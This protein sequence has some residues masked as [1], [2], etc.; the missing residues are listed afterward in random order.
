MRSNGDLAR[1][2][3]RLRPLSDAPWSP[4]VKVNDDPGTASQFEPAIGVDSS[5]NAYAV[6]ADW[7]NSD[8]DIYFSYRPAGGSWGAS[9]RVDDDAGTA[10]QYSPDIAVDSSR[11]AYAVWEDWRNGDSD[12]YFSYRPVGG[13]WGANVKVNDDPG[14]TPQE[15]PAIAVDSSGNAY[16]VW[17]DSRN[18]IFDIYFSYR[19]AGGSWGVNVKVNDDPGTADPYQPAIGVDS[20]GNAYAVWE[21]WR[22]GTDDIYFSYRPAGGSW[23]VNVRVDDDP[24]TASQF[25]PAIAVGPSGN[26]YA[27]WTDWRTPPYPAIYFSYRPAGGGWGANVEVNDD[28]GTGPQRYPAIA[29]DPSGNAYAVWTEGRPPL[30]DPDIYFS[31]RPAG[32]SWGASVR[33]DDD[34]GTAYQWYP[35]IAVDP[36]GNA[37][38]VWEDRRNDDP[39]IYFSYRVG[40]LAIHVYLPIV[41]KNYQP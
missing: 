8:S 16:A 27:V 3:S 14:T 40:A 21:D 4:N 12:I 37:Y 33:V 2:A 38:A 25:E 20:A 30:L 41:R 24:G 35:A 10:G 1:A 11:N 29:V 28:P 17:R 7:R 26:A 22:N 36:S 23:G 6:W 9:V 34:P 15:N 13:S 32:G 18:D 5:G 31:Y 19:P 39:D